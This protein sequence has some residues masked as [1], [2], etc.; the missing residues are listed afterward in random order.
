MKPLLG[1]TLDHRVQGM[2]T[3]P[4]V[5]EICNAALAREFRNTDAVSL[6]LI[7][8]EEELREFEAGSLVLYRK[9]PRRQGNR[10]VYERDGERVELVQE[11]LKL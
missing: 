2:V 9:R 11:E 8:S 3:L 6:T 7:A 4:Q 1:V 5:E 10:Y